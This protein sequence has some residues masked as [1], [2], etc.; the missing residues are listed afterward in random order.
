MGLKKYEVMVRQNSD[1]TMDYLITKYKRVMN[2]FQEKSTNKNENGKYIFIWYAEIFD[3]RT[4]KTYKV[5]CDY[6]TNLYHIENEYITKD[7]KVIKGVIYTSVVID[8]LLEE[9]EKLKLELTF[10][11]AESVGRDIS[12]NKDLKV[13]ILT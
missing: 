5:F 4:N 11:K 13:K 2:K 7:N 12:N 1:K 3:S 9:I 8:E 10:L 6:A